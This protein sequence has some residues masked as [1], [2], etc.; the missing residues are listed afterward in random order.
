MSY[1]IT[2]SLESKHPDRAHAV[3]QIE[4][5]ARIGRQQGFQL[6]PRNFTAADIEQVVAAPQD[7]T[8]RADWAWHDLIA[9]RAGIYIWNARLPEG[10]TKVYPTEAY[11]CWVETPRRR[12]LVGLAEYPKVVPGTDVATDLKPW[13]WHSTVKAHSA[14][15]V[16]EIVP[17]FDLLRTLPGLAI[18]V[19]DETGYWA[20]R[21]ALGPQAGG[22]LL[23]EKV[24]LEA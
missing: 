11:T 16:F 15:D 1:L 8:N 5:F 18:K 4:R 7:S 21:K 20:N 6:Q 10:Y 12:L 3:E 2:F 13:S 9:Y 17:V 19:D 22:R 23:I 14:G 24:G